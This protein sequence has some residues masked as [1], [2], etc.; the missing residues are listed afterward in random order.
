VKPCVSISNANVVALLGY[1][2]LITADVVNKETHLK[3]KGKKNNTMRLAI[4]INVRNNPSQVLRAN[5]E[6]TFDPN[7]K[8]LHR[9]I[10]L[11]PLT[12]SQLTNP[13]LYARDAGLAVCI[14]KPADHSEYPETALN[15]VWCPNE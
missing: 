1:H 12:V 3:Q 2:V 5:L 4:P 7:V 10:T 6:H 15:D 11:L 14:S 9:P 8:L 13:P